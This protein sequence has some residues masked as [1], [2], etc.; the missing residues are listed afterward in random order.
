MAG[1]ADPILTEDARPEVRALD[2]DPGRVGARSVLSAGRIVIPQV[3]DAVGADDL[4]KDAARAKPELRDSTH[5]FLRAVDD[6]VQEQAG[7]WLSRANDE[8]AH[9][10]LHRHLAI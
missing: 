5:R 2:L 7:V 3:S 4:V 8:G 9:H 10:V 1:L 6:E